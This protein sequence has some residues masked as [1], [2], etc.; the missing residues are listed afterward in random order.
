MKYKVVCKSCQSS[1]VVDIDQQRRINWGSAD[2]IISGRFR[3]DN[4]WGWQCICG[5]N[6]LMTDQEKRVIRNHQQPDPQDIKQV[7]NN[8]KPQR[9]KFAMET[10]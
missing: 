1:E 3:L 10:M 4:S 5:N 7:L 2:R 9:P 6:D 8:L